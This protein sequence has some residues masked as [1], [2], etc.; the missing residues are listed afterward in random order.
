MNKRF[1][2]D[3][4]ACRQEK[5]VRFL[6]LRVRGSEDVLICLQCEIRLTEMLRWMIEVGMDAKK[7]AF[8]NRKR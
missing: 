7:S 6:D 3:C 2:G 1:Q 8:K 5:E 4:C